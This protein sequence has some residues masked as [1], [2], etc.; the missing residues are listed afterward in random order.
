MRKKQGLTFHSITVQLKACSDIKPT[1]HIILNSLAVMCAKSQAQNYGV[2]RKVIALGIIPTV[3]GPALPV[4]KRVIAVVA[5]DWCV[6][7]ILFMSEIPLFI[8][9]IRYCDEYTVVN[10]CL[11]MTF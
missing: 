2:D 8:S 4:G 1:D 11:F 3:L 6:T 7:K 5:N 9:L 10:A